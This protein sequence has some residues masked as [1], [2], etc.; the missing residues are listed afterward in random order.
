MKIYKHIAV[1][2]DCNTIRVTRLFSDPLN[3]FFFFW[4]PT[5]MFSCGQPYSKYYRVL[6][7][8]IFLNNDSNRHS[9]HMRSSPFARHNPIGNIFFLI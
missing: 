4:F 9:P 3:F 6:N 8:N 1:R 2:L 5:A 7:V